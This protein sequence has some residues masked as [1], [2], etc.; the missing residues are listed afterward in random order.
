MSP[1]KEKTDSSNSKKQPSQREL[2][3]T[4]VIQTNFPINMEQNVIPAP[5]ITTNKKEN[6]NKKEL[7]KSLNKKVIDLQKTNDKI[8]IDEVTSDDE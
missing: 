1:E 3:P 8:L 5:I 6:L 4:S 7:D 2:M